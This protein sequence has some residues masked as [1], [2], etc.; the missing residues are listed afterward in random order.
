MKYI[1]YLLLVL[2]LIGG[3]VVFVEEFDSVRESFSYLEDQIK[4]GKLIAENN[5][6]EYMSTYLSI[7]FVYGNLYELSVDIK[8]EVEGESNF[9]IAYYIG[10]DD[11][12]DLKLFEDGRGVVYF[13]G[14]DGQILFDDYINNYKI[15]EFNKITAEILKD[16]LVF[17]I[18]NKS[19]FEIDTT[20]FFLK[21]FFINQQKK[22]RLEVERVEVVE[23]KD[24]YN[25]K[26]RDNGQTTYKNTFDKKDKRINFNS[27]GRLEGILEDGQVRVKNLNNEEFEVVTIK[28]GLYLWGIYTY[29]VEV[30]EFENE[31]Y[32]QFSYILFGDNGDIIYYRLTSDFDIKIDMYNSETEE[33][34]N[35]YF[36]QPFNYKKGE[37]TKIS[38]INNNNNGEIVFL[39]NDKAFFGTYTGEF[40]LDHVSFGTYQLDNLTLDNFEIKEYIV[41]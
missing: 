10:N 33:Y 1:I 15:G 38:F 23:V 29:E 12:V 37:K 39:M 32:G 35:L 20:N 13:S 31:R 14:N 7:P 36:G 28:Y 21:E 30:V 3:E 6:E 16:K 27:E 18:N 2:N 8:G 11:Y 41:E 34:N 40:L 5:D 9:G 25:Y 24:S 26:F 4:E 22:G 19:F 17:S